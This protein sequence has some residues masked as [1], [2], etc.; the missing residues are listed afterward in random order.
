M[1]RSSFISNIFSRRKLAPGS[2]VR[3]APGYLDT[4]KQDRKN[5]SWMRKIKGTVLSIEDGFCRVEWDI[6]GSKSISR[7]PLENL[8]DE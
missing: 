6:F 3:L 7:E 8:V 1:K 2:V 4:I 5:Y